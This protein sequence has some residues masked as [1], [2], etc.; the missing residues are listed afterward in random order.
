MKKKLIIGV[1]IAATTAL[2]Q[3]KNTKNYSVSATTKISNV[4][5]KVGDKVK[6]GD[7]LLTCSSSNR[8]F[9][10]YYA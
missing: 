10:K 1:L 8:V 7:I 9:Y 6:K 2:I 5:V 3:S 4:N